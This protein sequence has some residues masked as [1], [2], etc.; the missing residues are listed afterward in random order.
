MRAKRVLG[1]A[2]AGAVLAGSALTAASTAAAP[3]SY[4]DGRAGIGDPYFPLTGNG[5]I[6]VRHYRLQLRYQPPANA[7]ALVGH[8][9]GRATIKV[10]ALQNLRSFHLDLRGL[11]ASRVL[12]DGRAARFTQEPNELVIEPR[13]RLRKGQRFT[14]EV[15]YA[16]R[17]GQPLDNTGAPYGWVTFADGA[18]VAN[19]PEGAGTWFPVNDHPRDKA[20]YDFAITVPRGKVGVANGVLVGQRRAGSWTTWRWH[21]PDPM[22]AY[23]ATASVGNY[24]L[25]TYR[26]PRGLPIIDAV[27]RDLP[28]TADDVLD[29]QPEMI[30]YFESLFGRYPFVAYGGILDDD[31][32]GYALE[33]QTRPIYSRGTGENTVAHELAHQWF[34]NAVSPER[35]QDIWLNEG[36]A[37]YLSWLWRERDGGGPTV[38]QR[39]DSVLARPATD[40]FWDVVVA[41]PGAEGLFE[42]AVYDRG[43]ATLHA[44]RA[45]IGD[46]DF[47]RLARTWVRRY[48][49][50]VAT[51]EDF[52]ALA[53]RVSGMQLDR[54]FTV[55]LRTP[56]KPTS[57]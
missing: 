1:T 57:W 23:L 54:F 15:R 43:A 52:E 2:V 47:F 32:V 9:Q 6:D 42:S 55:W 4:V 17:T 48:D 10:R 41:D 29:Q 40:A 38:Q 13:K 28:A 26:G 25:D 33:T 19:E 37:T 12:V 22:A 35:W 20:T 45:K 24:R 53:E 7:S 16:G 39:Y 18:F 8:L 51:T 27:D 14:V 44:L 34:G 30:A 49:D 36:W 31:S 21:A 50:S 46:D 3:P 5:G 11:R 56:E